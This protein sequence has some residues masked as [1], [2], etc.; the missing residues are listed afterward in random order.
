VVA[1]ITFTDVSKHFGRNA[2]LSHLNLH[3]EKGK[4]TFIIGKSGEGKSVTLKHI[5]GLMQ[6]SS[7]K[8]HVDGIEISSLP[9]RELLAMRKNFG[10]LFQQAALFDHLTA[11]ENCLFPLQEQ[12][13][14]NSHKSNLLRAET[15]LA[16]IGM[17]A[18]RHR[19]PSELST[20]E[21][22]R[23]G[24]ARALACRPKVLLY[25]E[26]TTGMDPLVSEM[27][28]NLI[29]E[30][31]QSEKDLT[32]VVISHDL[33]A[34]MATAERIIMLYKGAAILSGS[35]EEFRRSND[36]VVRQFFAGKVEGPMEFL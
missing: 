2:V 14:Q 16:Q 27:V 25:D 5:I 6:P 8:V 28:D 29:V 7:G 23:V 9:T 12:F 30:V 31:N 36:P 26:P 33:K 24:L 32:S 13:R 34:T 35:P 11:L 17:S 18:A 15:V 4:I 22:K 19:Y 21:K 10:V 1:V 3:I 20:G